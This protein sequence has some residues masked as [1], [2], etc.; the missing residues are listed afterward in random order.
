MVS[1]VLSDE[2]VSLSK[3]ANSGSS[4]AKSFLSFRKEALVPKAH[5]GAFL[6]SALVFSEPRCIE[7]LKDDLDD[8]EAACWHALQTNLEETA[9]DRY[10]LCWIG[11]VRRRIVRWCRWIQLSSRCR[12]TNRRHAAA[13][14]ASTKARADKISSGESH[15]SFGGGEFPSAFAPT[16]DS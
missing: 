12:R 5:L 7:P 16:F 6:D 2:F 8:F 15:R 14:S 1:M 10:M 4:A 9:R 13:L 3:K 11:T